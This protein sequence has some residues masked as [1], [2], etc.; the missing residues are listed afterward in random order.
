MNK[1]Y[2][3]KPKLVNANNTE[4]T[5]SHDT[6]SVYDAEISNNELNSP[7]EYEIGLKNGQNPDSSSM[8]DHGSSCR[9]FR[10]V[11]MTTSAEPVAFL[12]SKPR[13]QIQ[14]QIK[15]QRI[16]ST[17]SSQSDRDNDSHDEQHDFNT[18]AKPNDKFRKGKAKK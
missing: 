5:S 15:N 1:K 9:F 11:A 16:T 3:S 18:N 13:F 14:N 2:V 8:D 12:P 17:S 10:P 6:A 7:Q 4:I